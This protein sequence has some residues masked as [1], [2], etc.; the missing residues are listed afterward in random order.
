LNGLGWWGRVRCDGDGSTGFGFCG[1]APAVGVVVFDGGERAGGGG[2]A[3]FEPVE[4]L[5]R[6][7][8]PTLKEWRVM[9]EAGALNALPEVGHQ[10]QAMWQVELPFHEDLLAGGGMEA[11]DVL[12]AMTVGE[13]V[14]ADFS[15]QGATTGPHPL[16]LWRW[17]GS[18]SAASGR[19]RRRGTASF[20][21]RTRQGS[22]TFLCRK[23]RFSGCGG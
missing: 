13:R 18:R 19:G 23:R 5:V 14:A 9:A 22:R 20:R 8:G 6:R 12:P 2:E 15:A 16:R 3:G 17:W 7:V 10:R 21:W 4:D 11:R 1:T